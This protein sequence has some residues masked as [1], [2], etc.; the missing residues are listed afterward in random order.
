MC[1]VTWQRENG[2]YQLLCNRDERKSRGIASAPRVYRSSAATNYVS[3]RDRDHG[4]TWL[5]ANEHGLTLCLLNANGQNARASISRGA[6]PQA[7][8]DA[9]NAEEA[10]RLLLKLDLPRFKPFTLAGLDASSGAHIARW[11]GTMLQLS[12]DPSPLGLLTSSSLDPAKASE[13]RS[14]E[15]AKGRHESLLSFHQSHGDGDLRFSPCMHRDDAETVSFSWISC[16]D[17]ELRFYYSPGSPCR[18]TQG[19]T[20]RLPC[21]CKS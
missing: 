2:G 5:A 9:R 13:L 12:Q 17:G 20:W 21:S 6:L 19:R 3:P 4:G 8:I 14:C 15:L 7:L 16:Q 18:E 10:M 11:D 1:T